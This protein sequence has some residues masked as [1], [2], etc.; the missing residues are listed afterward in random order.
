MEDD[1]QDRHD[2]R[3]CL[4]R[5]FYGRHTHCTMQDMMEVKERRA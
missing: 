5:E 3:L 1:L 4:I 2:V